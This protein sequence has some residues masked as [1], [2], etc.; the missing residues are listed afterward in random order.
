MNKI[1]KLHFDTVKRVFWFHSPKLYKSYDT[2]SK[3]KRYSKEWK[4]VQRQD[5]Y[6]NS[7]LKALKNSIEVARNFK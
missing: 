6:E 2:F 5:I 3:M 7:D 1:G 4:G